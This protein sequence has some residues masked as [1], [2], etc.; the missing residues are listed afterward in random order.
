M[1]PRA[2]R[3]PTPP[4]PAVPATA[5][6][7]HVRTSTSSPPRR[8]QATPPP[9]VAGRHSP[10]SSNAPP[11]A[12]LPVA[13]LLSTS[14][15]PMDTF[16]RGSTAPQQ[17][18][19]YISRHVTPPPRQSYASGSLRTTKGASVPGRNSRSR[20][21]SPPFRPTSPPDKTRSLNSLSTSIPP[22]PSPSTA[23]AGVSLGKRAASDRTPPPEYGGRGKTPALIG[24]TGPTYKKP[25]A[26]EA[27]G[28]YGRSKAPPTK[29]CQTCKEPKTPEEMPNG[30]YRFSC[31]DCQLRKA[32]GSPNISAQRQ[33]QCGRKFTA[34]ARL[35]ES[36][37]RLC[38]CCR[39]VECITCRTRKP[40]NQFGDLRR[41]CI[42]CQQVSTE[43]KLQGDQ[44]TFDTEFAA[45]QARLPGGPPSPLAPW[46]GEERQTQWSALVER[47]KALNL[48]KRSAHRME[49]Q[50]KSPVASWCNSIVVPNGGRFFGNDTERCLKKS[51][52]TT[53]PV[54]AIDG[55][56][57]TFL[58]SRILP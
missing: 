10:S 11:R 28:P 5:S 14:V 17:P 45:F 58:G 7:T 3:T 12:S 48:R 16:R 57:K 40:G 31:N 54:T 13:S 55:S 30:S 51:A 44:K 9:P 25:A 49:S 4:K 20:E 18:S 29:K 21:G 53:R 22:D 2:P 1:H 41:P 47:Q 46:T 32:T 8:I 33:C 56:S 19:R 35:T 43:R 27:T 37:P 52:K 34:P 38:E 6:S 15:N 42:H 39:M 36:A 50:H 26:S 24:P 23:R